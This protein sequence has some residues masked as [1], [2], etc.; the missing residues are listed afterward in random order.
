MLSMLT[1]VDKME[2][3]ISCE[4]DT[5][6]ERATKREEIKTHLLELLR[7]TKTVKPRRLRGAPPER[8]YWQVAS[9]QT[10]EQLQ[11]IIHSFQS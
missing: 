2:Q 4:D 7:P 8:I 5:P 11:Q 6:E 1:L 3:I 9:F 10:L